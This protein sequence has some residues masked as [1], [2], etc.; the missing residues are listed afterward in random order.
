[1]R[2]EKGQSME[3]QNNVFGK[4]Q[5]DSKAIINPRYVKESNIQNLL[6]SI[7]Q[8]TADFTARPMLFIPIFFDTICEGQRNFKIP[9]WCYNTVWKF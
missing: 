3:R 2:C 1:M 5:N 6:Y 8:N 7:E 4:W 9:D